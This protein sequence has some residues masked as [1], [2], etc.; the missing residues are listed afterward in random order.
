MKYLKLIII[1]L[2]ILNFNS[3][4]KEQ[5]T[6][7]ETSTETVS[8]ETENTHLSAEDFS[9]KISENADA[10]VLDV[11]TP[12]EFLGG[13]ILN[14]QN[15]S[16]SDDFENRIT[17]L[18][19]NKPVFVYCLSGARSAN[20]AE[21]LQNQGF[22]KVYNLEAGIL[23][24]RAAN[25]P[26]TT[27]NTV[28]DNGMTKQDF[29]KELNTDKMV[30]VDFYADWCEPCKKMKPYI[31]EISESMKQQVKVVRINADENKELCK[32][33]NINALP[34]I[35]VYKN[36]AVVWEKIGFVPKEEVLKYL[37]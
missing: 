26:E 21:I 16:I 29:E 23:S 7:Q 20:A 37:K 3:C 9:K 25:L 8:A 14:A 32:E 10:I 13:H 6:T 34:V 1:T 35:K 27:D 11:G 19:H 22:T 17:N 30:L 31:D 36:N 33:M 15:I 18:D 2:I 28:P 24:W 5:S 12:Q 4:K